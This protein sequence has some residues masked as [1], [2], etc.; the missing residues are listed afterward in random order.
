MDSRRVRRT[1]DILAYASLILDIC[2]AVITTFS[3]LGNHTP[4]QFLVP[5]NYLLTL[6]V[7]LSVALFL[8]LVLLKLTEQRAPIG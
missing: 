2:I 5:V 4:Q 6:V 7:I 8:I 1:L 3:I